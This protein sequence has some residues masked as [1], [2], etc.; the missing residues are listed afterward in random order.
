MLDESGMAGL[1]MAHSLEIEDIVPVREYERVAQDVKGRWKSLSG[2][3]APQMRFRRGQG[4]IRS[5]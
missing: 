2:P 1:P 4:V 5:G 3:A